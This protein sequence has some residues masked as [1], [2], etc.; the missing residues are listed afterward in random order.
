MKRI[1]LLIGVAILSLTLLLAGS[2]RAADATSPGVPPGGP[3]IFTNLYYAS[4]HAERHD[5]DI[6]L[7][8][9]GSNFPVVIWIHGGGWNHNSKNGP[10][11][12]S[13][14]PLGY[15]LVSINFRQSSMA[16]WPAQIIDCKSAIRWLRAHAAEYSL[17]ADHIGVWGM[18][19][20]G[21]MAAMLGVTGDT[22][23]FDQGE[24]LNYSSAVQAVGDWSGPTDLLTMSVYPTT[25]DWKWGTRGSPEFFL[26]GG[27]VQTNTDKAVNASPVFYVDK[28]SAPFIIMHGDKDSTVP[29]QQ[30]Q[31]IAY[32]LKRAGVPVEYHVVVEGGHG[33]P[34]D[35][36]EGPEART[37]LHA[38][39]NKYLKPGQPNAPK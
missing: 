22:R 29:V 8:A 20:G 36:F 7:P 30:A 32:L 5:L 25:N 2:S 39:F 27:T 11:G 21:H 12:R 24:N 31:E 34:K 6:Y 4:D 33:S 17:D 28:N 10:G 37:W 23:E 16:K 3:R 26:L 38:F 35:A 13:F 9:T 1:Q 19:S 15:A 14:I 18:S